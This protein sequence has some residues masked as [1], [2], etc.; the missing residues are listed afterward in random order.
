M[1]KDSKT[2]C[3][4]KDQRHRPSQLFLLRVWL[5][6]NGESKGPEDWSGRVQHAVTGEA[7]Y[8]HGCRELAQAL[9]RMISRSNADRASETKAD[10]E[11]ED[12]A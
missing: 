8:F 3:D 6:Q 11:Q 12:E 10:S 2:A 7:H 9:R 1:D 4:Q 5:G